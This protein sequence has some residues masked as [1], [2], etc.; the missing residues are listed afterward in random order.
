MTTTNEYTSPS[1]SSPSSARGPRTG[2]WVVLAALAILGVV[3]SLWYQGVFDPKPRVAL[4]TGGEGQYGDLIVQGAQEAA[5]RHG[6]RL[7]PIRP[8][9]DEPSQTK[10]LRDLIDK[11]YDGIAV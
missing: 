5:I 1:S 9:S 10:A 3:A 2:R 11:G 4:V 7:D 8:G 6:V